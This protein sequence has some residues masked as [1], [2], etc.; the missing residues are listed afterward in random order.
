MK[1]MV[2]IQFKVTL[3]KTVVWLLPST[4][5]L[6]SL[7]FFTMV[8]IIGLGGCNIDTNSKLLIGSIQT[9]PKCRISLQERPFL[10]VPFLG[11]GPSM[12]VKESQLLQGAYNPDKKS[13]KS[14]MEKSIRPNQDLV[15]SLKHLFKILP[16][17]AKVLL[18]MVGFVEDYLLAN[19]LGSR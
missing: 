15:P 3:P 12:P 8:V 18:L 14:I 10:T 4:L 5:L 6:V 9:N 11:R 7:I 2:L 13:C 17:Y 16:I 1:T 19:Y